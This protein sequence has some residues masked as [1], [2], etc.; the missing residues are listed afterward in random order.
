M[1]AVDHLF[2]FSSEP[3][4]AWCKSAE[5]MPFMATFG[6]HSKMRFL[7]GKKGQAVLLLDISLL[8]ENQAVTQSQVFPRQAMVGKT[9][10]ER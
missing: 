8:D 1:K 9:V 2:R 6:K 5:K 7:M 4:L 10:S 3:L